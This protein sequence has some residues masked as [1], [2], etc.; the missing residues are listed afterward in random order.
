MN[1]VG[2]RAH[3]AG[4]WRVALPAD[5]FLLHVAP[6]KWRWGSE[7]PSTIAITPHALWACV[8]TVALLELHCGY[9]G[10]DR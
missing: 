10:R 3:I 4:I 9:H 8:T 7:C 1:V 6:N 2:T 5:F